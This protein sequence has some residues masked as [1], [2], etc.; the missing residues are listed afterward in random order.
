MYYR[1]NWAP[2]NI[3]TESENNEMRVRVLDYKVQGEMPHCRPFEI[4]N[5]K[6]LLSMRQA[7]T[8]TS[9]FVREHSNVVAAY[10]AARGNA[11]S[12][13]MRIYTSTAFPNN[14]NALPQ[15]PVRKEGNT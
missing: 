12:K 7:N 13:P 11:P 5:W 14:P 15:V 4:W 6:G 3:L 2:F 9:H 10:H 8:S 1:N